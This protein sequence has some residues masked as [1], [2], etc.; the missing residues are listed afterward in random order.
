MYVGLFLILI[1]IPISLPKLFDVNPSLIFL[2]VVLF[3]RIFSF[4]FLLETTTS[5]N[6]VIA[7]SS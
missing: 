3:P 5:C 6:S 7:S 2:E 4:N 1:F